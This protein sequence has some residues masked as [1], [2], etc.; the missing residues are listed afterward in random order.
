MSD[1]GLFLANVARQ[2]YILKAVDDSPKSSGFTLRNPGHGW[3]AIHIRELGHLQKTVPYIFSTTN[4]SEISQAGHQ[5][6]TFLFLLP[7]TKWKTFCD[8]NL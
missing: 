5:E 8:T 4:F 2:L 3:R 7:R 6:E 1:R